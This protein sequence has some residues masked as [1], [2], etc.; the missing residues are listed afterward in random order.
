MATS[1]PEGAAAVCREASARQR[2]SQTE[3]AFLNILEDGVDEQLRLQQ[4]QK[5]IFN[6]LD[7]A[8][9]EQVALAQTYR[10]V[11]NIMEDGAAEQLHLR[12]TQNA[13]I[14][15]LDDTAEDDARRAQM[16]RALINILDDDALDHDLQRSAQR[17]L[18][19]IL[20]DAGTEAARLQDVQRAVMNILADLDQ[21]VADRIR[22]QALLS[23]LNAELDERV[24]LRTAALEASNRE[25]EA[26]AYAVAHDLRAPLRAIDGFGRKLEQQ[27]ADALGAEG[28]RQVT[29]VRCNAR[30]MGQ[31]IDDLLG[32]TRMGRREMATVVVDMAAV[33]AAVVEDAKA[34][35]PQRRMQVRIGALPN[36]IGD[37]AMLQRV[38]RNLVANAVK[39]SCHCD[40]AHIDIDGQPDGNAVTY[41]I[42]D[43][44]VGFDMRYVDKLF[45]IFQRLHGID[46]FEGTGVGLAMSRRIIERHGGRIWADAEPGKGACFYFSLPAAGLAVTGEI[47]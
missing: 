24:R 8:G 36:A 22:A 46:E 1:L 13:L 44:G 45:V 20:D 9:Q 17:A 23:R 12:D 14:N 34:E 29:V 5:A 40:P 16:Q 11:L 18:M 7:D 6:I 10:A 21:E 38:W 31:L 28:Q 33:V 2:L 41:S 27:F 3:T 43:D 4:M 26:F 42:R 25:L 19:N 15:I 35:V 32:F 47:A 30:R 39:F 37:P